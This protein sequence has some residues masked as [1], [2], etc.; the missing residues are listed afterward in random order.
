MSEELKKAIEERER[1]TRGEP[2]EGNYRDLQQRAKDLGIPANQS[3]DD[4]LKAIT[5][6]EEKG[7]PEGSA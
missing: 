6:A 5:K 7:E 2:E 4:L 1:R 3:S